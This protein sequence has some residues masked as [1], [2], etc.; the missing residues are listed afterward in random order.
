MP[1]SGLALVLALAAGGAFFFKHYEIRGLEHV[2]IVPRAAAGGRAAANREGAGW[3]GTLGDGRREGTV[4]VGSFNIQVFGEQK[5][6]NA[7][8]VEVLAEIARRFDVLA[9]QEVRAKGQD[10]LPRFV[11]A[12]NAS[13][14]KYDYVI[15][16]RL[17]RSNSKEQYAFVYNRETIETDPEAVYTVHDPDDLLHREPLVAP[18]RVRGPEPARAWTFTL[19]NVHTDPDEARDEVNV[20]DDVYRAVRNDGRSEDDVIVLGDFNV[21]EQYLGQVALIPDIGWAISGVPTNT[22][23]TT[24]LD[25]LVFG[26][27]ATVEYT[28][29]AGVLDLVREFN[30]TVDEALE[31]SDH[32]PVWAEFSVVEG[33]SGGR[34]ASLPR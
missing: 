22:R 2:E 4:R 31:V 24:M 1:K 15:G 20:L 7:K 10:V 27:L 8:V 12:I 32:L 14:A 5:L 16:P 26:R 28:G 3:T 25:N 23:G 6:A 13:G 21:D 33:E 11:A 29:R 17:G 34:M 19:V 18:F 9:I 30:L